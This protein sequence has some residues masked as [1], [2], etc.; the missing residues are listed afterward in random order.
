MKTL[1]LL[2]IVISQ[3]FTNED[4]FP[5]NSP[6]FISLG[7]NCWS[8]QAIRHAGLR[9]CAFPFDW[10]FSKDADGLNRAFDEDFAHFTDKEYFVKDDYDRVAVRNTYYGMI[11]THDWPFHGNSISED[12]YGPYLDAIKMKY[13][14]RIE[15]FRKL[16]NFKGKVFFLRT[17]STYPDIVSESTEKARKLKTALDRY[18]PNLNFTLVILSCSDPLI[19]EIEEMEGVM[20][21]K[22]KG[23]TNFDNYL[24]MFRQLI[25]L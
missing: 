9:E 15:R 8:A 25:Q 22:I 5:V 23:L 7:C 1:I 10:L 20:E 14:R 18:F 3:L 21:F 12:L 2:C 4:L 17:F 11:Y 13:D 6:I 19:P 24:N 16:K